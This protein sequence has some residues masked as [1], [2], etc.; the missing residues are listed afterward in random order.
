MESETAVQRSG[1]AGQKT[2]PWD[3]QMFDQ[4]TFKA[5]FGI[6]ALTKSEDGLYSTREWLSG[7]NQ[8]WD[9]NGQDS[10]RMELEGPEVRLDRLEEKGEKD[11]SNQLLV[12]VMYEHLQIRTA[13]SSPPEVK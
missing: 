4:V 12:G 2:I 5:C 7:R 1:F 3:R 6:R 11:G 13:P 10:D 9:D 8:R